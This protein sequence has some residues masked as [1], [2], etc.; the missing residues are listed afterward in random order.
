MNQVS[1]DATA[2]VESTRDRVMGKGVRLT[3][4]DTLLEY[5]ESPR[6]SLQS[7]ALTAHIPTLSYH[8]HLRT[9]TLANI[10]PRT[11]MSDTLKTFAST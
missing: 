4:S 3:V 6:G 8:M 1:G 5:S 11:C 9:P 10:S 7:V 2:P